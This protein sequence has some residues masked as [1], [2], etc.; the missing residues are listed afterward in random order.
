ME[1]DQGMEE[2][3]VWNFGNYLRTALFLLFACAILSHDRTDLYLLEGGIDGPEIYRN[4]IGFLGA[5]TARIM[6]YT[7]GLAAYPVLLI[8]FLLL[9]RRFIP[10]LPR[11]GTLWWALPAVLLGASM[12]F[13]M[14]PQQFIAETDRLGIGRMEQSSLALSGGVLGASLAAP[15][16]S[17]VLDAGLVR[18]YIGDV[19]TILV[20]L[21]FLLPAIVFLFLRDWFPVL[22]IA[23]RADPK[24]QEEPEAEEPEVQPVPAGHTGRI[25]T[26]GNPEG[27]VWNPPV[28]EPEIHQFTEAEP[29][30]DEESEDEAE[31][32]ASGFKNALGKFL[33]LRTA[34]PAKTDEPEAENEDDDIVV[35]PIR[36]PAQT[37]QRPSAVIR[38]P[39]EVV[40]PPQKRRNVQ[41][42]PGA[43]IRDPDEL[44]VTPR[45]RP[46]A[47]TPAPQP[48]PAPAPAPQ[49]QEEI[50]DE[51]P[52]EPAVEQDKDVEPEADI[53]EEPVI[54]APAPQ[55]APR[56]IPVQTFAE[57]KAKFDHAS[58]PPAPA[59]EPPPPP[60]VYEEYHLPSP[61]LLD[62]HADAIAEEDQAYIREASLS[63]EK[64]LES[65]GVNGY[66]SNITVGPRVTQFEI[67]LNP[68]VRVE[69]VTSIQNNIAMAMEAQ[70]IRIRAPI[71]GKD[72]VGIEVPNKASS[73]VYL[74][75]L[76]ESATW[77]ESRAAIPILLGRDIAGSV[78][79][80]DLSK[81]PHLLIAGSTGSGKS[82]CMNTLIMS[83]L[84]RFSPDELKLIMVDPKVVELEMYRPIPHLITPVVNDPKKVPLA[85]RWGVNEMERRYM[86]L[87]KVKAKN[88]AA[89]NSRPPDPQPVIDDYGE[90]VP[91]KLPI[92]II[93]IDELADIMMTDAKSDVETSICRIAQKGRAAGVHLVI[94]TQ[95]PRK[96]VVTGLIKANI[97]TK[98]AFR[99]SNGMDSRV[100][101]D[102]VGAEKLLGNGDMLF[103][104]P[105][106]ANLERIQ[107]AYVSDSEIAKVIDEV[108]A[109]RP[110]LFDDG[111]FASADEE[112]EDEDVKGRRGK[113]KAP[114]G[115]RDGGGYDDELDDY[116]EVDGMANSDIIKAA[117]DKYLEPT[118]PPIMVRALEIII[119][120]Q[121]VSTSYLQRRL[122]IGYNK[123]AD[124]IDKLEQRHVISAPLPGGQ[125]RTILITDGLE[126]PND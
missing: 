7:F 51:Q 56:P 95:S 90:V 68:G 29:E 97:P 106:A 23:F 36:P 102:A 49:P 54:P 16:A 76:L 9:L 48:A 24:P 15:Q 82:V 89:F 1:L 81:A 50:Y 124:I 3:S 113:G 65:F 71:P 28:S 26:P 47:V 34:P 87:A 14:W 83:L 122:G 55:P 125:K 118:D 2:R 18:R 19:G 75:P 103:N 108:A 86:V 67:A 10:G 39:N 72:A 123:A 21:A 20:A 78:Y 11:R 112:E 99:V 73:T 22:K 104:P 117:A 53:D 85:L 33:G 77:R 43:V 79:L 46:V 61:M 58:P 17:A 38:D 74:R 63:L 110:Q 69:K 121:Q 92:L 60:P 44:V 96:E 30:K 64:T 93:I 41:P 31:E 88:L 120:E 114:K 80:T 27:E 6:F 66:V 57:N 105:G 37:M 35:P 115:G 91:P 98:I 62:R 59:D 109:Q 119:N 126:T 101:L 13:A 52:E 4:W 42:A 111:I 84:F 5:H 116:D 8:V 45:P 70:S 40:A 25:Y 94:A 32:K 107:G 12:L 100:I